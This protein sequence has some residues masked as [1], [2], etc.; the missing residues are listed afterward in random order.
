MGSILD[1]S[2]GRPFSTNGSVSGSRMRDYDPTATAFH[3]NGFADEGYGNFPLPHIATFNAIYSSGSNTYWQDR[4]DEAIRAARENALVMRRDAFLMSLLQERKLAVASIPWELEIPDEKDARQRVVRDTIKRAIEGIADLRRIMFALLEAVWYGRYAVEVEWEWIKIH[5]KKVLT[6]ADWFPINGDKL[7]WNFDGVPYVLTNATI[8]QPRDDVTLV[9]TTA[10]GRGLLLKGTWR[11]RFFIHRHEMDDSDYFEGESA[12]GVWGVGVR[13]RIFWMDWVRR[14]YME[15]ITTFLERVGLGVT[16]WYY[17]GGNPQ[18]LN[19]VA[20]AAKN[21]SRRA[22]LFVPIF[23]D[24]KGSPRGLVERIETPVNGVDALRM[25]KEDIEQ[26]I[27]RY[28][29]GQEASSK[30]EGSSGL[31]NQASALFQ[32]DTKEKIAAWDA[33]NLAETLTGNARN[34]GLVYLIQRW[35]FPETMP[36][37]PGGFRVKFKFGIEKQDPQKRLDSAE[38]VLRMGLSLKA[39]EVRAAGGFTKPDVGDETISMGAGQPGQP[40]QPGAGGA[41]APGQ[42]GQPVVNDPNADNGFE[43]PFP[44]GAAQNEEEALT[45]QSDGNF[46]YEDES[47]QTTELNAVTRDMLARKSNTAQQPPHTAAPPGWTVYHGARGGIGW[48]NSLTGK[49]I[50]ATSGRDP[51]KKNT[52]DKLDPTPRGS[53]IPIATAAARRRINGMALAKWYAEQWNILAE[54]GLQPEESDKHEAGLELYDTGAG[55]WFD[56]NGDKR[57]KAISVRTPEEREKSQGLSQYAAERS[58]EGGATINGIF[59]PGGEWIPAAA[60]AKQGDMQKQEVSQQHG[61][62]ASTR[63]ARGP[64]DMGKLRSAIAPHSGTPMTG[65]QLRNARQTYDSLMQGHGELMMHR[66]EELAQGAQKV[67]STIKPDMP[68]AEELR[69]RFTERLASYGQMLNWA[70]EQGMTPK[71][72][73]HPDEQGAEEPATGAAPAPTGAA[74]PQLPP[75]GPTGEQAAAPQ[76]APPAAAAPTGA[77]A[78]GTPAPAQQAG[79]ESDEQFE[80]NERREM[81]QQQGVMSDE[82]RAERNANWSKQID[83]LDKE[84]GN[85]KDS[86][87]VKKIVAS[88]RNDYGKVPALIGALAYFKA[89]KEGKSKEEAGDVMVAAR[90][91][92]GALTDDKDARLDE[93]DLNAE[94]VAPGRE[95]TAPQASQVNRPQFGKPDLGDSNPSKDHQFLSLVAPENRKGLRAASYTTDDGSA[96]LDITTK[97]G[98]RA[99]ELAIH[100]DATKPASKMFPKDMPDGA[101]AFRIS[102]IYLNK[103]L[104]GKGIG[105]AMY[106]EAFKM[107][108]DGARLWNSATEP[109]A[110]E[111]LQKM[112][113]KGLIEYKT[114][115]GGGHIA[116]LTD[117]GKNYQPQ[118]G[119]PQ[120]EAKKPGSDLQEADALLADIDSVLSRSQE[121][122][123]KAP[124]KIVLGKEANMIQGGVDKLTPQEAGDLFQKLRGMSRPAKEKIRESLGMDSES[125]AKVADD[126]SQRSNSAGT[127]SAPPTPAAAE[128]EAPLSTSITSAVADWKRG[129]R[130]AADMPADEL[131]KALKSGGKNLTPADYRKSVIDLHDKG[132]IRL[133][134]WSGSFVRIPDKS[135]AVTQGEID[136]RTPIADGDHETRLSKA[137]ANGEKIYYWTRPGST[138]TAATPSP[139]TAP[140]Q[141][142]RDPTRSEPITAQNYDK[143][144]PLSDREWN[145]ALEMGAG[146]KPGS[147]LSTR[148]FASYTPPQGQAALQAAEK[149]SKNIQP[150]SST[151]RTTI[152]QFF[153]QM[154]QAVPSITMPQLH[155]ILLRMANAGQIGMAPYTRAGTEIDVNSSIPAD[156][157]RFYYV[158]P[159]KNGPGVA[160]GNPQRSSVDDAI[161]KITKATSQDAP[162]SSFGA[163]L[164]ETATINAAL[165]GEKFAKGITNF[166]VTAALADAQIIGKS[167]SATHGLRATIK[168]P[169]ALRVVLEAAQTGKYQGKPVS[170]P[171]ALLQVALAAAKSR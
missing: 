93:A 108:P 19:A 22:N 97:S 90:K 14:E 112:A 27:E 105:R 61:T 43:P 45:K 37:Q 115:P 88:N 171:Y 7:G 141:P 41:M 163:A 121:V 107:L 24:G 72:S 149:L 161:D 3:K 31:G 6:V 67:L 92:A 109:D 136:G 5:G 30:G 21:Q 32:R 33:T 127:T 49:V 28:I 87:Q 73:D 168:N 34:P 74:S 81:D 39:D 99:G 157:E 11:D 118:T 114:E 38:K 160:P 52:K 13:S 148:D 133:S 162:S 129:E 70:E 131:F 96:Y 123:A 65:E 156:G 12:G 140:Q 146:G 8:V 20:A 23:S 91:E 132:D 98:K 35:S 166:D 15:W 60:I 117:K 152:P 153:E 110:K 86:P 142:Q 135:L 44:N 122:E 137:A 17:D 104:R 120:R 66:I 125:W 113:D 138:Q 47:R 116:W 62:S 144:W 69:Q 29:V 2:T 106:M 54:L 111:A 53:A 18:A 42:P 101:Q 159:G 119:V 77:Q 124:G 167:E 143:Q 158:I 128:K 71:D 56:A 9:N 40:G 126:L 63:A 1:P 57:W 151:D 83:S 164:S 78:A 25:L 102:S 170:D 134:G 150:R 75:A 95:V 36:D 4:W 100:Q 79:A 145:K 58:P 46:L 51:Y 76:A 147:T 89:L 130:G 64:V 48:K 169:N 26:K 16:L 139:A 154:K 165:Q 82:K 59:Y 68:N 84:L 103:A 55:L 50:Y 85:I 80:A 155:G 94:P 10:G